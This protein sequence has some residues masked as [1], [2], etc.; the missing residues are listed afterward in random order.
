M[1][2]NGGDAPLS[3]PKGSKDASAGTGTGKDES[4]KSKSKA[5][6]NFDRY[7]EV[8]QSS[9]S[10]GPSWANEASTV[11]KPAIATEAPLPVGADAVSQQD[12]QP[13]AEGMSDLD[14]M[15]KHMSKNVVDEEKV[16]EQSGDE[17]DVDEP[18]VC[19]QRLCT[20]FHILTV[21]RSHPKKIKCQLSQQ[22]LRIL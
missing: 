1:S 20:T 18:K 21:L 11:V 7:M 8:M 15:R 10:K 16:F 5:E 17:M 13:S 19:T 2:A 9:A 6:K 14:W 3:D 12:D 22:N 4:G